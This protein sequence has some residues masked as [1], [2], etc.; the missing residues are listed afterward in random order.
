MDKDTD[1]RS[2]E[3]IAFGNTPDELELYALDKAREVFGQQV[4]LRIRRSYQMHE[5]LL[6]TRLN[7]AL[8]LKKNWT[9]D[10]TVEVAS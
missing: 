2:I 10:V 8:F 5:P 1:R 9:A 3:V 6:G 4:P 7:R